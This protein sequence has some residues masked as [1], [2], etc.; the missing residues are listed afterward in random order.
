MD[1]ALERARDR[2]SIGLESNSSRGRA[3]GALLGSLGLARECKYVHIWL[4]SIPELTS[5]ESGKE[6]PQR[7]LWAAVEAQFDL[8][9]LDDPPG[10]LRA[11]SG[12]AKT[13]VGHPWR[14]KVGRRYPGS[15]FG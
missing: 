13:A 1:P 7:S 5:S 8:R 15:C 6:E 2:D 12:V 11:L 3:P 10:R 9:P 4:R 14:E